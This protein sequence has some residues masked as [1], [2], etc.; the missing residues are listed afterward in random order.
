VAFKPISLD[1]TTSYVSFR[2]PAIDWDGM[3]L[4]EIEKKAKG[5]KK[6]ATD[7]LK[8]AVKSELLISIATKAAKHPGDAEKAMQLKDGLQPTRFVLGAI[9]PGEMNRI[10]DEC[11]ASYDNPAK[12]RVQRV[13]LARVYGVSAADRKYAKR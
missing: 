7:Q 9:E 3:V 5:K 4:A 1:A 10:Q 6:T 8:I 11:G 2:D 12:F 13:A